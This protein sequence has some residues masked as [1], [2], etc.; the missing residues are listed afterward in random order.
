MRMSP[1]FIQITEENNDIMSFKG[2][3]PI[4]QT[5]DLGISI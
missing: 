1:D 3:P 2:S 4:N 5:Q